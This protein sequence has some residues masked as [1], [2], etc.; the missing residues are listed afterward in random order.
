MLKTLQ[1]RKQKTEIMMKLRLKNNSVKFENS[2]LLILL[3]SAL[4]IRPAMF[5]FNTFIFSQVP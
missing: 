2:T 5:T 4:K 1:D 3:R